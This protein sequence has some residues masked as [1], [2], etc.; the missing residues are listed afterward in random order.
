MEKE[1]IYK[2]KS[3]KYNMNK[4]GEASIW[5][6]LIWIGMLLILGWAFLKS[7]GIINTAVWIQMVPYYGA[8]IGGIGIIYKLGKIKKGIETTDS[9][10]DN[11]LQM[12]EDFQKVQ[13]NQELCFEG[14]LKGSPFNR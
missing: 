7:F 10:V 13:H 2:D 6:Y 3:I 5:D 1:N 4:K 12:K 9:K 8:G 11:I 14:K